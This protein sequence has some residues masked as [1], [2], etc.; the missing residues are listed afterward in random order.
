MGFVEIHASERD[1]GVGAYCTGD[2]G[3]TSS[4]GPL[5]RVLPLDKCGH[6]NAPKPFPQYTPSKSP[7]PLKKTS[8]HIL[9]AAAKAEDSHYLVQII[10][11]TTC[12]YDKKGSCLVWRYDVRVVMRSTTGGLLGTQDF[13]LE[14]R[15]VGHYVICGWRSTSA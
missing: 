2:G 10:V 5:L 1:V 11:R 14:L 8:R 13:G 3:T 9:R 4:P 12:G 7:F 15:P 6:H